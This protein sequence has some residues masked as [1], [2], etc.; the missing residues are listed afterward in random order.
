[1]G[2]G[3]WEVL[4]KA[5]VGCSQGLSSIG[6]T[7]LPSLHSE[8]SSQHWTSLSGKCSVTGNRLSRVKYFWT[9]KINFMTSSRF[10]CVEVV[11][12]SRFSEDIHTALQ[13]LRSLGMISVCFV[14]NLRIT[15]IIIYVYI[16][17]YIYRF[18]DPSP[19]TLWLLPNGQPLLI[20]F[21]TR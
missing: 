11:K 13:K 9:A 12:Q 2:T 3:M 20:I 10:G 16:Y 6:S 18:R 14:W 1:M 8:V 17:I 5:F 7:S 15:R 19:I 4:A 21:W